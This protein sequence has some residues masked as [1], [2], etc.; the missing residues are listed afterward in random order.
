LQDLIPE[1]KEK[2]DREI[3]FQQSLRI[4]VNNFLQNEM[5]M[6]NAMKF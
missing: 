6:E 2:D 1:K 3:L 4:P 5:R